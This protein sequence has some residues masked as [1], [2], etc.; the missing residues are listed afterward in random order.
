[1]NRLLIA[2]CFVALALSPLNANDQRARVLMQAA[3]AK[4]TIEGDLGAAIKLY[5]DAEK[6]AGSNRPLVAQAL[7][8]M[9]AAY[10]KLGDAEAQKIYRRLVRDFSDQ[11][12]PVAIARARLGPEEHSAR[13]AILKDVPDLNASGNVTSDGRYAA[14]VNSSTGNIAVRD[15]VAGTS[16]EVTARKDYI[17][18]QPVISRDGQFVAYQSF[19]TCVE[20]TPFVALSNGVLCVL[21][22][23]GEP[24]VRAR[25][26][27]DNADIQR[28]EPMDWSPDGNSIAA[29]LGR[30]DG[31]SQI[32]IVNVRNGSAAI[33]HSTDWRGATR[34]FFSPDG[35][36]VAFDVPAGDATDELDVRVVAVDG[37]HGSTVVRDSSQNVPMG[38]TLDGR[39]VLFASDRAGSMGLWAQRVTNGKPEG[40]ARLVHPGLGGAR[41]L[42]VTRNGSLFFAVQTGGRDI[43]VLTVDLAAGKQ[44]S[45]ATRVINRYVGTNLMPQWSSDGKFLAY[46]SQRGFSTNGGRIIGIRE[47]ATGTV[48]ELRPRLTYINGLNWAPDNSALVTMGTDFRGRSGI[49]TIDSRTGEATFL[50][51]GD[52]PKYA[53]DGRHLFYGKSTEM[54]IKSVIERHLATG[55][56]RTVLTGEF[57]IF[58]ISPDGRWLAAATGG[59]LGSAAHEIA[60]FSVETG[61]KRIV[62]R[63]Q[64]GERIPSYVT[65]PWTPDGRAV[66]MRKQRPNEE[67]WLVPTDGG[68]PR[69]ID[70]QVKGWA[71]GPV[72]AFSLHPDGRQ[73]AATRLREDVGPEVRVLENFLSAMK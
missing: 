11:T 57:A 22:I 49:F 58:S 62:H 47:A 69:K 24:A 56:E 63:A 32:G 23:A 21:P 36:Y 72:G 46:A 66:L 70:A 9:A 19:N 73:I 38:W 55:A 18:Y 7:L 6:E 15:L 5:K 65:M 13:G 3:E 17:V 41:S 43:E 28:V 52:Y 16:R 30:E 45:P 51:E 50:T 60:I 59:V 29:M 54:P 14:Y 31:T 61:E 8:K 25:T 48:R 35:R 67:L 37:S 64:P 44:T 68:Q 4:A 12:E 42:G 27:V 1:M 2:A 53:P 10:Q 40:T 71:F 20:R 34:I 39:Y 26:V 33:L